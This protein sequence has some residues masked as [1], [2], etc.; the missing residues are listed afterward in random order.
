MLAR[1]ADPEPWHARVAT[2]CF[3]APLTCATCG[4][5]LGGP[6]SHALSASPPTPSQAPPVAVPPAAAMPPAQWAAPPPVAQP[7]QAAPV[8][9]DDD[10]DFWPIVIA[11]NYA[12]F[13]TLCVYFFANQNFTSAFYSHIFAVLISPIIIGMDAY[14]LTERK[15]ALFSVM[16]QNPGSR[17]MA[18]LPIIIFALVAWPLASPIHLL[19][20]AR[21]LKRGWGWVIFILL[22]I[23]LEAAF[24]FFANRE[25]L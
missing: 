17:L 2:K 5:P 19:W 10:L 21:T 22:L 18:S 16:S 3:P 6:S 20:R 23:P 8:A 9:D 12:L 4:Q 7:G 1:P 15:I 14:Q 25:V 11:L 24:V 13:L